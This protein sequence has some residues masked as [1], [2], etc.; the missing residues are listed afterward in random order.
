MIDSL[1]A[2]LLV[3]HL[4]VMI[5]GALAFFFPALLQLMIRPPPGSDAAAALG[6]LASWGLDA[7]KFARKLGELR[8]SQRRGIAHL[9]AIVLVVILLLSGCAWLRSSPV[10]HEAELVLHAADTACG[11]VTL[12]LIHI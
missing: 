8:D 10:V 3:N 4:D 9:D 2:W 1:K 12:S 5:S 7:E 11:V 6:A